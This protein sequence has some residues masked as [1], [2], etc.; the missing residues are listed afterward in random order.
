[1][2]SIRQT[3]R[4][5][6]FKSYHFPCLFH[7]VWR[8]RG[9]SLHTQGLKNK[10][11]QQHPGHV[12]LLTPFPLLV[13]FL[14][15]TLSTP[16]TFESRK[17]TIC[18]TL[19]ACLLVPCSARVHPHTHTLPHAPSPLGPSFPAQFSLEA[20]SKQCPVSQIT[21]RVYTAL[22]SKQTRVSLQTLESSVPGG[23]GTPG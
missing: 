10:T 5:A 23:G 6:P 18:T 8:G 1:M 17:N 22:K 15:R 3:F 7:V 12:T 14:S 19:L 20:L 4:K 21:V 16:S 2:L 11:I 9:S 13:L